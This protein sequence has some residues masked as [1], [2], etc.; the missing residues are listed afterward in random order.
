MQKDHLKKCCEK[1]AG[2]W[3]RRREGARKRTWQHGVRLTRPLSRALCDGKLSQQAEIEWSN[4][5]MISI[6]HFSV[7]FP[8]F[9]SANTSF[10]HTSHML[11]KLFGF[12]GQKHN[13]RKMD[14]SFEFNN[15]LVRGSSQFFKFLQSC[16]VNA[17]P[18]GVTNNRPNATR[19]CKQCT[20]I[21]WNFL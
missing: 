4:M 19:N 9:L 7:H 18:C 20:S 10:S 8:I 17:K 5:S 12:F 14:S 16:A 2:L 1:C 13:C 15:P 11:G 6:F 3:K 21:C